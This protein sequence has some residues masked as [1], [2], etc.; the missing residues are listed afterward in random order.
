MQSHTSKYELYVHL[1]TKETTKLKAVVIVIH[2]TLE[3]L[4][5]QQVHKA[6]EVHK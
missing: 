4:A 3:K 6:V 2:Q 1:R 5:Y